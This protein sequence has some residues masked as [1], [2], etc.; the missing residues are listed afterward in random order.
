[1][2]LQAVSLYASRVLS[3]DRDNAL[4]DRD[5]EIP[6]DCHAN[7]I[8]GPNAPLCLPRVNHA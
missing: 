5:T 2:R 4:D 6:A 3:R 1:M 8:A 7:F